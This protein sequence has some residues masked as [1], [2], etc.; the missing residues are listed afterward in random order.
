MN[1]ERRLSRVAW[2]MRQLSWPGAVSMVL[3]LATHWGYGTTHAAESAHDRGLRLLNEGKCDLAIAAFDEI[4]ERE[5]H[6]AEAYNNRGVCYGRIGRL[7][8]AL[9][10]FT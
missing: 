7:D 4:I 6:R 10:D 8:Q 3:I 2:V 1:C 5:P 9:S